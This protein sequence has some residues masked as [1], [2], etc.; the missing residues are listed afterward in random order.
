MA[1]TWRSFL[2]TGSDDPSSWHKALPADGECGSCGCPLLDDAEFSLGK[3]AHRWD[4]A[5]EGWIV[6]FTVNF[7]KDTAKYFIRYE[8]DKVV[9]SDPVPV[10]EDRLDRGTPSEQVPVS[11]GSTVGPSSYFQIK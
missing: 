10:V 4:A 1:K 7:G 8:S 9:A 2:P 6:N 11:P 3:K 5:N